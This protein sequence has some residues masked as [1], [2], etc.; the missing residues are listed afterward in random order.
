MFFLPF[1]QLMH[2]CFNSVIKTIERNFPS[3]F[4]VSVPEE[5]KAVKTLHWLFPFPAGVGLFFLLLRGM[6]TGY[7]QITGDFSFLMALY[8]ISIRSDLMLNG[9]MFCKET[10]EKAKKKKK[11]EYS[12]L[13]CPARC[14][15]LYWVFLCS[16]LQTQVRRTSP[17]RPENP[18]S[19]QKNTFEESLQEF[20]V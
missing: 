10:R 15:C 7:M 17:L 13:S 5:V 18:F 14:R 20:T 12:L 9:N 8:V 4:G 1:T 2:L 3:H 6:Q 16:E 19:S 11:Q